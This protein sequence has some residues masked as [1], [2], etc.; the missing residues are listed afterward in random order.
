MFA[1]ETA[2]RRFTRIIC[3]TALVAVAACH[4]DGQMPPQPAPP[5]TGAVPEVVSLEVSQD[6]LLLAQI[7]AGKELDVTAL[8]ADGNPVSVALDWTS[9][10]SLVV[11]ADRS[12]GVTAMGIGSAVLTAT[13]LAA[14]HGGDDDLTVRVSVSVAD[15]AGGVVVV[16]AETVVS[17]LDLISDPATDPLD[18]LVTTFV[19]DPEGPTVSPGDKLIVDD[20]SVFGDVTSVDPVAEG[21][22]ITLERGLLDGFFVNA[23]IEETFEFEDFSWV[24]GD[25]PPRRSANT[26]VAGNQGLKV[27]AENE[28]VAESTGKDILSGDCSFDNPQMA[29]E[30]DV[31]LQVDAQFED[32]RLV[33]SLEYVAEVLVGG[34]IALEMDVRVPMSG[35]IEFSETYSATGKCEL[36]LYTAEIGTKFAKVQIPIAIGASHTVSAN[37]TEGRFNVTGYMDTTVRFGLRYTVSEL[38]TSIKEGEID[39]ENLSVDFQYPDLTSDGDLR[40]S[41][42][43]ELYAQVK[44]VAVLGFGLFSIDRDIDSFRYGA[45]INVDVATP[46]RQARD[47]SYQA[48]VFLSAFI[49]RDF[50]DPLFAARAMALFFPAISILDA[51]D[52]LS[53]IDLTELL[54][55]DLDFKI[56]E[57]PKGLM[58]ASTLEATEGE[59]VTFALDLDP[60]T[61]LGVYH[62][63]DVRIYRV[64]GDGLDTVLTPFAT[65]VTTP[66]QTH[67]EWTW[68]PDASDAEAGLVRFVPFVSSDR[69]VYSTFQ[70]DDVLE[71]A[72]LPEDV[73]P[74][75]DIVERYSIDLDVAAQDAAGDE[76]FDLNYGNDNQ[77][78][79]VNQTISRT[80][81]G[82]N[83]TSRATADSQSVTARVSIAGSA[84]ATRDLFA[85]STAIYD[86][87]ATGLE[88]GTQVTLVATLA[89][90]DSADTSGAFDAPLD[91]AAFRVTAGVG[92]SSVDGLLWSDGGTATLYIDP[93]S[94]GVAEWDTP[95]GNNGLPGFQGG[96]FQFSSPPLSV[97][98][99]GELE[100]RLA[101]ALEADVYLTEGES[102]GVVGAYRLDVSF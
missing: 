63:G 95:D 46:T 3:L 80:T 7:G 11:T 5:P 94:N 8:D 61:F 23:V 93:E 85:D 16:P 96:T 92:V 65:L 1:P 76:I 82:I 50:E 14:D 22:R 87:A 4:D 28:S 26:A 25:V 53:I 100:I 74:D 77:P 98:P 13:L 15:M 68:T 47:D 67:F 40:G 18:G 91:F 51:L 86:Y 29:S 60:T 72:V 44:A 97:G 81:A 43:S 27:P 21:T 12:G 33:P 31:N 42:V 38:L 30:F 24:G 39:T 64:T 57:T 71:I 20:W 59:E 36:V 19:I 75:V 45:R 84:S 49:K 48:E 69:F 102:G 2:F 79:P 90:I 17:A 73:P 10:D 89:P 32:L 52:S 66:G 35:F 99:S 101:L 62:V 6:Q 78:Q 37:S 55:F 9:D 56:S 70:V 58:V 83:V 54:S 41:M 34:S 88:P